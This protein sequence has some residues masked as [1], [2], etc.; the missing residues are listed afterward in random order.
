MCFVGR[1]QDTIN[2]LP[3]G[4]HSPSGDTTAKPDGVVEFDGNTVAVEVAPETFGGRLESH[5]TIS[6]WLKHERQSVEAEEVKQHILCNADGEG[7]CT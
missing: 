7:T 3:E 5:F 1:H 2:L 4:K 6:T